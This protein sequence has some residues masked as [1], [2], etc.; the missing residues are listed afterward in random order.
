M[1]T[2]TLSAGVDIILEQVHKL[3]D[4]DKIYLLSFQ[5]DILMR[6]Q[7]LKNRMP[8]VFSIDRL[9]ESQDIKDADDANCKQINIKYDHICF[10]NIQDIHQA[11]LRVGIY[12][13]NNDEQIEQLMQ[14]NVDAVYID[15]MYMINANRQ[16]FTL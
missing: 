13:I 12:A 2:D 4:T 10:K 7:E 6:L 11:G 9:C 3:A 14:S 15:D 16:S 8:T 5:Y 1:S